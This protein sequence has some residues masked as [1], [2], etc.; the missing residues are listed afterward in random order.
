MVRLQI[1]SV[2]V[3]V[4]LISLVSLV[5]QTSNAHFGKSRR[6][7][8]FDPRLLCYQTKNF[9]FNLFIKTSNL[10]LKRLQEVEDVTTT[11]STTTTTTTTPYP[12]VVNHNA[13]AFYYPWYGSPKI[14]GDWV[15]ISKNL[16]P[17]LFSKT[18]VRFI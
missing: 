1:R 5:W 18:D 14:D 6:Q 10:Y 4:G 9:F 15:W 8:N 16:F 12:C 7:V 2:L 3:F 13:H 11:T 17:R